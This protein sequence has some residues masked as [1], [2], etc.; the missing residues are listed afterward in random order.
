MRVR[1][2]DR[3]AG[4]FTLLEVLIALSIL[5]FGLLTVALMQ[6]SSLREGT[7]GK[8]TSSAAAV[9]RDVMERVQVLPWAQVGNT[10]GFVV[11]GFVNDA[12][13]G[14]G[15]VAIRSR[16]ASAGN[17][18]EHVFN[19]TWRVSAVGGT[20][21]LRNVDVVVTWVEDGGM[22]RTLTLSSVKY[23]G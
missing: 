14:P 20:T 17:Q 9:A 12:T 2:T 18:V 8:H 15:A 6:L 13:Y 7:T 5:A 1:T 22:T 4:G 23:N 3:K 19:V 10:V 11:P 21:T 16:S